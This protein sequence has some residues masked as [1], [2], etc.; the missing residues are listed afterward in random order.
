[1]TRMMAACALAGSVLVPSS[2]L[3]F[4]LPATIDVE[5]CWLNV[6]N[7]VFFKATPVVTA[8]ILYPNQGDLYS[9]MGMVGTYQFDPISGALSFSTIFAPGSV[10]SGYV[11]STG[12]ID[13][14]AFST[15]TYSFLGDFY[16]VGG[17]P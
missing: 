5:I 9:S 8:P 15:G 7:D 12:C 17:C 10:F 14:E 2:A 4:T 1:M 13:G 3:A 11:D 6:C 16:T